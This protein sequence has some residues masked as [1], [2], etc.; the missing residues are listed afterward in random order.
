M[1]QSI[2]FF[3]GD[4][5]VCNRLAQFVAKRNVK[6]KVAPLQSDFAR[7]ILKLNYTRVLKLNSIVLFENNGI[8]LKSEAVLR[9]MKK[10]GNFWPLLYVFKW[11]PLF[12]RDKIYDF[13]AHNRQ[14]WFGRDKHC[15]IPRSEL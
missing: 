4:C 12:I 14:K 9:L 13:F 5:Y 11:V 2:V 6:I 15:E 3:D 10:M 8:Y 1:T 7:S